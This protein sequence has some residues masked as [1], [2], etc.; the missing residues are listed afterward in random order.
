MA[1]R[2]TARRRAA[3]DLCIVDHSCASAPRGLSIR[4]AARA[5]PSLGGAYQ[6]S[7]DMAAIRGMT[8]S[9]NSVS[10]D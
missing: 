8:W 9:S 2:D 7:Q 10:R 4:L 3:W 6:C 5:L 1:V